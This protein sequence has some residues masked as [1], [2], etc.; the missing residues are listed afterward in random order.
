MGILITTWVLCNPVSDK[1]TCTYEQLTRN[2]TM[3]PKLTFK[4]NTAGILI[5]VL[6][7][8]VHISGKPEGK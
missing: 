6:G 8:W 4:Y 1:S 5:P 7:L 2:S 3:I